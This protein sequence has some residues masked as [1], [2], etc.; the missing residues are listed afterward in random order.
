MTTCI[1]LDIKVGGEWLEDLVTNYGGLKVG[2]RADGGPFSLTWEQTL[3]VNDLPPALVSSGTRVPV[4]VQAGGARVWSG[5]I[6]SSAWASG[7][8]SAAGMCRQ[9]ETAV[10][11]GYP[12]GPTLDVGAAVYF[13]GQRGSFPVGTL[14]S[15]PVLSPD[16][17]TDA[18]TLA[19]LLDAHA[20]KAGV[21]WRVTPD[22]R[23]YTRADPTVPTLF[24]EPGVAQ[25]GVSTQKTATAIFL[26]YSNRAEL[27][28]TKTLYVWSGDQ[29]LERIVDFKD[30]PWM[31]AVEADALARKIL[32]KTSGQRTL[33]GSVTIPAGAI[34]NGAGIEVDLAMIGGQE[35][36]RLEG[37]YDGRNGRSSTDFVIDEASYDQRAQEITL[38]PVEAEPTSFEDVMKS[39]GGEAR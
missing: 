9:A 28:A 38:T 30:A 7:E 34:T 12:V 1:P 36:I 22:A 39:M 2:H 3:S 8:M 5:F 18:N 31:T 11:A 32:A 16:T 23:L 15:L 4:T 27:G 19:A 37:A 35:M 29:S 24:V 17:P 14:S 21:R 6:D 33:S 10:A 25:L 26:A 13:A 20:Q